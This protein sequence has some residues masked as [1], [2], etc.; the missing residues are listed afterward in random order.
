MDKEQ[1]TDGYINFS[2]KFL[3]GKFQYNRLRNY[4][5]IISNSENYINVKRAGY[6]DIN[7]FLKKAFIEK[8]LLYF[9]LK[10]VI[11]IVFSVNIYYLSKAFLLALYKKITMNIGFQYFIFWFFIKFKKA[12][13]KKNP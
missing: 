5:N 6:T 4:Y 8:S 11:P 10:R 13:A 7:A 1:L 3:D 12:A 9:H 2:K